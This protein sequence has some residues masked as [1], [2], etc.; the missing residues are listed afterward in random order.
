MQLE[1]LLRRVMEG[2]VS[3]SFPYSRL[4]WQWGG[5]VGYTGIKSR[6]LYS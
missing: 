5:A 3:H 1:L 2:L 6:D 4:F